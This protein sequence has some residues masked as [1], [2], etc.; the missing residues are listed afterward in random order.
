MAACDAVPPEGVQELRF[1]ERALSG[2]LDRLRRDAALD[3]EVH[4]D[5]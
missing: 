3:E 5:A 4:V 1:L 2:D